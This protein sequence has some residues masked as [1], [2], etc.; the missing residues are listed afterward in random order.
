MSSEPELH[1]GDVAAAR[2][3]FPNAPDDWLDLST[4]I[5]ADPYPVG[6]LPADAWT[7]LPEP[8]SVRALEADAAAA[9]GARAE[10]VVAA[11]GTQALIQWLPRLLPARRVAILDFTY[12]EHAGGWRAAGA[13]V[14][15][16][17][18]IEALAGADVA[19]VVNP[20]NPDG[21]L[22]SA[23]RLAQLARALGSRGGGLIVDEAFI[24]VYPPAASLASRLPDKG[25]VLLRSFGKTYGL[26]GLRLGFAIATPD[27]APR[28]RAAVGPWAVSGPAIAIGR[29]AL[30][31][32]VW[33][34]ATASRLEAAAARLD[35]LLRAAG[36]EVPGGTPL[37]RL[38]S[39]AKAARMFQRLGEAGILVRRFPARPDWLRF[40]I[41]LHE[42]D[43]AR[44]KR[45][46]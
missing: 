6:E 45:A 24:D 29:R 40:G 36:F 12:A 26:A 39:H 11:P 23:D 21:R 46:L 38:G 30:V 33:L 13:Q 27:L 18:E 14:D 4:G 44:L 19:V 37:F 34:R 20:N 5:N 9:Y 3:R 43:W 2:L 22:V 10:S 16:V 7:R 31:D 41:P 8:A 17:S 1:G 25:V 42:K 15:V 32:D 35:A 28:L